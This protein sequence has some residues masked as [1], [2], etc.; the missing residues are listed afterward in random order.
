M[1]NQYTPPPKQL[2][3]YQI[4]ALKQNLIAALLVISG[5]ILLVWSMLPPSYN[6][7]LSVIGKGKPVIAVIYDNENEVS[8]RLMEAY[9][10]IRH[11]YEHQIEFIAID[12]N[13]P[14]GQPFLI[15]NNILSANAV[16]YSAS[17]ERI[18]NIHGPKE[19]AE[20]VLSIQ[21]TFNY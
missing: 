1:F 18:L 6:T 2:R 8:L 20:L 4:G 15:K 17:G 21:Q 5:L 7:D 3:I 9:N 13:S 16:Y 10:T 19:A 12:K 11:N 14:Q